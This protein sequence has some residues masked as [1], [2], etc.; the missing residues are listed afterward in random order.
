M[1]VPQHVIAAAGCI[2]AGVAAGVLVWRAPE[3]WLPVGAGI[4]VTGLALALYGLWHG[5]HHP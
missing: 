1:F 5:R 4:A 2:L 3:A